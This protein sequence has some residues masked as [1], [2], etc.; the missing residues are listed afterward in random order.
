MDSASQEWVNNLAELIEKSKEVIQFINEK[1]LHQL[2]EY[3][4]QLEQFKELNDV[5]LEKYLE[6]PQEI[7]DSQIS[8][9]KDYAE[10]V[11]QA[12]LYS[13]GKD[14]I[15]PI[16]KAEIQD[17]R[18]SNKAWE[19]PGFNFIKQFYL[20]LDQ[21]VKN[22]ITKMDGID[23]ATHQR[24]TFFVR[25]YLNSLAPSN[26]VASNPE[27]LQ[28]TL[29]SKGK[30]LLQGLEHFYE[31]LKK[32]DGPFNINITDQ[33]A[34]KVG[35]NI[36]ITP[37]RV[38][39]QNELIQLIQYEAST[40]E[41]LKRPL[42]IIPPWIN[43]YYILDLTPQ[44]SLV[45]WAV[46]HGHTVFIISWRNPDTRHR[47]F[48][49]EDYMVLGILSAL[50]AIEQATGEPAINGL[51]FCIGG[52]LLSCTL[53]YLAKKNQKRILS[54]TYLTTMIDFS[55]PGELGV[56]MS[57]AKIKQTESQ[58]AEK[59]YLDGRT[60]AQTFNLLRDN[61]LIW[62]YFINNYLAGKE[63]L[64]FDLLYWNSDGSNLPE[65][66]HRFYLRNMYL[67][68][69]LP[70]P[71]ALILANTP[72]NIQEINVPAYFISTELDHI[73]PW[74]STY[75]GAQLHSGPVRFV[76]GGSGHIAGVVNPPYKMKYGYWTNPT[77][78]CSPERWLSNAKQQKGSWWLDWDSWIKKQDSS[79]VP[80]RKVGEGRLT[81]IEDAPGSYVKRQLN[82]D[83]HE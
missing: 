75:K 61:D 18:F 37:G 70:Q 68:N 52:T 35:K 26:F 5:L 30:N 73:A 82:E 29:D 66:A 67:K 45:K 13:L 31:D 20:L 27:I 12:A 76:L 49:F 58:M 47:H 34:F 36:A 15:E 39:Y 16:L 69:L 11:Q 83:I 17:K 71:N 46:D 81:V 65:E 41:V 59:G 56:F 74:K 40:T 54:A 23:P 55:E 25:T 57:E 28:L 80:A 79:L 51:G 3:I 14:N 24:I 1:Q 38:V 60:M 21:H 63:P 50:D 48:N 4:N 6:N 7:I 78:E 10:L 19:L 22:F 9:W 42:L 77:L 33:E 8:F 32:S 43:K 53:A 44:N 72:L 62:S 2:P 64:P